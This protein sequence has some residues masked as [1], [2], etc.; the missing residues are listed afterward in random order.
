MVQVVMEYIALYLEQ[1]LIMQEEQ[2]DTM[3]Q[4]QQDKVVVEPQHLLLEV[5]IQEVVELEQGLL[6]LR[7]EGQVLLF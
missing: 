3:E 2:P 4:E 6:L 7:M 5:L 1:Q